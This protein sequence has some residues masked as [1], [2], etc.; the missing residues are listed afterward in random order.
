MLQY[1]PLLDS[2]T[3]SISFLIRRSFLNRELAASLWFRLQHPRDELMK[4]KL[5]DDN[6]KE[7]KDNFRVGTEVNVYAHGEAINHPA[8]T[9]TSPIP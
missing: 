5:L 3:F 9:G 7:N 6:K 8:K 1:S 4:I 2:D